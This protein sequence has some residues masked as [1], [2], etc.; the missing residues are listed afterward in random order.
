MIVVA[1]NVGMIKS[2]RMRRTRFEQRETSKARCQKTV[3]IS[4]ALYRKPSAS[5]Y[6]D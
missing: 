3:L 1:A 4:P 6:R 2:S 5:S